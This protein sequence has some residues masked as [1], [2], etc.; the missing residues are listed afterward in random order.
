MV[1]L[2]KNTHYQSAFGI[3]AQN[4]N[5]VRFVYNIADIYCVPPGVTNFCIKKFIY[6]NALILPVFAVLK[7]SW[8]VHVKGSMVQLHSAGSY[9][10]SRHNVLQ[11]TLQFLQK[12]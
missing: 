11:R 7:H 9:S 4:H 5:Q 2:I 12:L 8:S 10:F 1:C 3:S 6:S